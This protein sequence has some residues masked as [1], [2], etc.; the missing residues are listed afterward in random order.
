MCNALVKMEAV[1]VLD[2]NNYSFG[3]KI[4]NIYMT[5][6]SS[7]WGFWEWRKAAY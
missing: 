1:Q 4:V 7:K 3:I 5:V 2:K 6:G